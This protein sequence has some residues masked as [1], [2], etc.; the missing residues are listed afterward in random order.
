MKKKLWVIGAIGAMALSFCGCQKEEE[1][2]STVTEQPVL[3][4]DESGYAGFGYLSAYTLNDEEKASVLYLPTDENA[5]VGGTCI[6]SKTEGVEATLNLNPMFQADMEKK[7]PEQ[8]L[9]YILDMEYSDVYT[10]DFTGL[11][12]SDVQETKDGGV[13]AEVSYLV[14]NDELKSM[15]ANWLGYYFTQLEDGR[16]FKVQIKTDSAKE[17][18]QTAAVIEELEKYFEIDLPFEA[19]MLQAKVDGYEPDE[20][21]TTK[22]N[23]EKV[24]YA[25]FDMYFPTGWTENKSMD[26]TI[27]AALAKQPE[28]DGAVLYTK[29]EEEYDLYMEQAIMLMQITS[30]GSSGEF[31][32]FSAGEEKVMERLLK[33]ELQKQYSGAQTDVEVIGQTELGYVIKMDVCGWEKISMHIYCIYR[34]DKAYEIAGAVSEDSPAKDE[35]FETVD[36]I[37]STVEVK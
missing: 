32:A 34:G 17:T 11:E 8:K 21:E 10:E 35:I 12:I 28:F 2:V 29:E 33:E 15:V 5:Y 16:E 6:I 23:G 26:G 1:V 13:T 4:V 36:Q 3:G 25:C 14:Y 30:G 20:L 27:E 7:S 22:M 37:Y 19:G 31:G 9:Q 18:A 24:S